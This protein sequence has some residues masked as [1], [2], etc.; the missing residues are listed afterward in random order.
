MWGDERNEQKQ[1]QIN[2]ERPSA[3]A[4]F[5]Q[6]PICFLTLRHVILA[7]IVWLQMRLSRD[8]CHFM[9]TKQSISSELWSLLKDELC[10]HVTLWGRDSI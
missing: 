8:V 6:K 10:Y 5:A 7:K 4:V 2:H 3:M 1:P 9:G